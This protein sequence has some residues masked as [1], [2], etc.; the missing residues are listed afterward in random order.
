VTHERVDGEHVEDRVVAPRPQRQAAAPPGL[1]GLQRTVGNRGVVGLIERKV[2]KPKGKGNV[3]SGK[4]KDK[5]EGHA[6]KDE[7]AEFKALAAQLNASHHDQF[8]KLLAYKLSKHEAHEGKVDKRATWMRFSPDDAVAQALDQSTDLTDADPEDRKAKIKRAAQ[9]KETA[10][11]VAYY[12]QAP[13][14]YEELI[15][16]ELEAAVNASE[17]ATWSRNIPAAGLVGVAKKMGAKEFVGKVLVPMRTDLYI[18]E[19]VQNAALM[20]Y[21]TESAPAPLGA[22]RDSMPQLRVGKEGIEKA[23]ADPRAKGAAPDPMLVIE[24]VFRAFVGNRG[25]DL[26]YFTNRLDDN[27]SILNGA[28]NEEALAAQAKLFAEMGKPVPKKPATQ[29]HDLLQVLK[30]TMKAVP[31]LTVN[32]G[33]DHIKNML[34]TKPL[35][36]QPQGLITKSFGGNV[37]DDGGLST[38]QIFFSGVNGKQSHTWLVINGVPFDPVMGTMGPEVAASVDGEFQWDAGGE[39]GGIAKEIGGSGRYIVV[40]KALK[41]AVNVHGF[42]PGYR[43]TATKPLGA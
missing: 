5:L 4:D 36:T 10:A 25:I 34:L 32:I 27:L 8:V 7:V 16:E 6:K 29:C 23:K 17:L 35:S 20:S 41:A 2:A 37:F 38:D 28:R 15:A 22:F 31:G 19:I 1:L 33:D 11:I 21:L 26:T 14:E 43:L 39:P 18:T 9:Y 12:K 3:I 13:G 40:D 30:L 24:H 42:G